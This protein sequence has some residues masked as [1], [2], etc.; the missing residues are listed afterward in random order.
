MRCTLWQF[1]PRDWYRSRGAIL[2]MSAIFLRKGCTVC[3]HSA[4]NPPQPPKD[5]YQYDY[6]MLFFSGAMNHSLN[7]LS[8]TRMFN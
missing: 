8:L 6:N 7:C 3:A 2:G 4:H 5:I 1:G